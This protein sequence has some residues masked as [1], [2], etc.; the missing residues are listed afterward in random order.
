MM[1]CGLAGEERL[2]PKGG[3]R[4]VAVDGLHRLHQIDSAKEMTDADASRFFHLAVSQARDLGVRLHFR[5]DF[6]RLRA[7]NRANRDSWVELFPVFDPSK[8]DLA[9]SPAIWIEGIDERGETVSTHAARFFRWRNTTLLDEARSLRLFYK[10]PVPHRAAGDYA[11]VP[12][13]PGARITG[14]TACVGALWVKPDYRSVGLIKV[15]ARV[16]KAFACLRWRA[17]VCWAFCDPAHFV[18]G[19]ARAFGPVAAEDGVTLRLGTLNLPAVL[20][21]QDRASVLDEIASALRHGEIESSRLTETTLMNTSFAR[22]QGMAN[23]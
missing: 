7:V 23:R 11:I 10:D 2:E 5:T 16:C 9:A 21:Y 15:T 14:D 17:A 12:D 1:Y 19:V 18:S 20:T 4:Y 8:S 22:C 13:S 3:G 6:E